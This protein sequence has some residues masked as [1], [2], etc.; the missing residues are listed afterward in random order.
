MQFCMHATSVRAALQHQ[1]LLNYR[2]V[3]SQ[4]HYSRIEPQLQW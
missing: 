2:F 3:N 4:A 1:V